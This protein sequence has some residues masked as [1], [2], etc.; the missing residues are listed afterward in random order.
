MV[1]LNVVV[2]EEDYVLEVQYL[3]LLDCDDWIDVVEV[4]FEKNDSILLWKEEVY[5]EKVYWEEVY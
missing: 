4:P 5:W 3:M 2:V 1:D